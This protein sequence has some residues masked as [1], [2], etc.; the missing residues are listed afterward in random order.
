MGIE[1][2]LSIESVFDNEGT[3]LDVKFTAVAATTGDTTLVA[4]VTSK[5]IR[6]LSFFGKADVAGLVLFE[7]DTGGTALT[8]DIN[9][10]ITDGFV[11][12][13]NPK[14]WFETVAGELLNLQLTTS[15][16]FDGCLSYCELE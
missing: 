16:N 5:K 1:K 12:P 7:S 2:E 4:A 8:G 15:A 10:G 6:V 9:V 3:Q 11:L 13:Y 14:G